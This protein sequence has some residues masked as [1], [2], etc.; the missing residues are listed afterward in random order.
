MAR[1]YSDDKLKERFE[2]REKY[3]SSS[4]SGG[5]Q[6]DLLFEPYHV[7]GTEYR[8]LAVLFFTNGACEPSVIADK[9]NILRQTMSKVTDSL[10]A[11]ALVTRSAHPT[12]RRR[13][14]IRLS[15]EGET[16]ARELLTLETDY[17]SAVTEHFTPEEL[18]RYR[19]LFQ[20]MHAARE[21]E[22]RRILEARALISKD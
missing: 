3:F 12:D 21:I 19:Q 17:N 4:L 13:I 1:K 22:L 15:P 10:A 5:K 9:L 11:K 20:K 6:H 7:T 8:V 14:F 16:L 18:E 2:H